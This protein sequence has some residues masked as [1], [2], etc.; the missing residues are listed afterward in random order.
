MRLRKRKTFFWQ[1]WNNLWL[2]FT[3]L[4]PAIWYAFDVW[5]VTARA[6]FRI[7]N[8]LAFE[9]PHTK[10]IYALFDKHWWTHQTQLREINS[11]WIFASA[12][13]SH[14][15]NASKFVVNEVLN[16]F[17]KNVSQQ[18]QMCPANFWLSQ[19]HR[20][21]RS[22]NAAAER[23]IRIAIIDMHHCHLSAAKTFRRL[24]VKRKV[25]DV[26]SGP[27]CVWV[28]YSLC[29]VITARAAW[30]LKY[31]LASCISYD[32]TR[33]IW[34]VAHCKQTYAQFVFIT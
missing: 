32:V 12:R 16:S 6:E 2:R 23:G 20:I 26:N 17:T 33:L 22:K 34:D 5:I 29:A 19:L 9:Q 31:C 27:Y 30:M 8:K 11:Y 25:F 28:W 21:L 1:T 10:L 24:E 15:V 14:S 4:W 7:W 3:S 13:R 18:L